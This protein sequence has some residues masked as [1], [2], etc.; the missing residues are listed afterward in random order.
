MHIKQQILNAMIESARHLH[1]M[2]A[3]VRNTSCDRYDLALSELV[4]AIR[5]Y[6]NVMDDEDF[7]WET[8]N[9]SHELAVWFTEKFDW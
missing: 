8:D 3:S 7:V 6:N 4:G 9:V 5:L 1:S 2:G